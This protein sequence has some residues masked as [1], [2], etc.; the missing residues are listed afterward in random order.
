MTGRD[1]T[2]PAADAAAVGDGDPL[3]RG[4]IEARLAELREQLAAGE[5]TMAELDRRRDEL[6]ATMLRIAG[7]AQVL[8]E[9]LGAPADTAA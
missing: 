9:L 3:P 5:R 2:A 4:A 8:A 6:R 7:A 1:A